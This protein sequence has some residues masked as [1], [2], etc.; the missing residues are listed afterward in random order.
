M[1]R[2]K[3][4]HVQNLLIFCP[5][6]TRSN[7]RA[8]FLPIERTNARKKKYN[9]INKFV[10]IG[11]KVSLCGQFTPGSTRMDK[12]FVVLLASPGRVRTNKDVSGV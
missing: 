2:G 5:I 1:C 6:I 3:R 12:G 10:Y 4:L 8:E 11:N 7:I 9:Y